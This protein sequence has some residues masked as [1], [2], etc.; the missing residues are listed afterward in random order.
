MCSTLTKLYNEP[1]PAGS[2]LF[3][4][5]LTTADRRHFWQV[6]PCF[7]CPVVGTCIPLAAQKRLLKKAGIDKKKRTPFEVHELLVASS[8]NPNRLS[9]CI[10]HFLNRRYGKV[11]QRL[12]PLDQAS[13]LDCFRSR[14]EGGEAASAVW[15]AAVHP[16][17]TD[18]HKRLIFSRIHMAMHAS[19]EQHA[20]LTRQLAAADNANAVLR[21][22]L[23][24]VTGSLRSAE[25]ENRQLKTVASAR[26]A[27]RTT[28]S[29]NT[30]TDGT[31]SPGSL[32]LENRLLKA[33]LAGVQR[34][35]QALDRRTDEARKKNQQLADAL[36]RQQ[37]RNHQLR[38]QMRTVVS[39]LRSL[40]RCD[41]RCPAFDLCRKRVLIV[42]GITRMESLYRKLIEGSGGVFDYHDGYMKKGDRALEVRLKRADVVL[43]PV[44]CNSHA[45]C[46][47][48]KNLARKHNKKVHMLASTSLSTISRVIRDGAVQ[49]SIN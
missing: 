8:E 21:Q 46:S 39:A 49:R 15:A 41:D 47:V 25:K 4:P 37:R 45:A 7:R 12:L 38:S 43:C 32:T 14:F 3:S 1:V 28:V 33:E 48:V 24:A 31:P 26:R 34:Q 20:K 17:L 44:S 9:R 16:G 40:D 35:M 19:S 10:D 2:G 6:D 13:F 5:A 11:V 29:R 42:G 22:R 23:K 18:E 30:G 27:Q 36:D